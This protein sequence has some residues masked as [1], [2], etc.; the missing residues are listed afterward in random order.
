MEVPETQGSEWR[1]HLPRS[2]G[3]TPYRSFGKA[4]KPGSEAM[5]SGS[6]PNP[7]VEAALVKISFPFITKVWV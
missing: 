4:K 3:S 1:S 7:T 5:P 6:T 2:K